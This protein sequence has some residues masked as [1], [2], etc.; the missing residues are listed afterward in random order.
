MNVEGRWE[1][2]VGVMDGAGVCVSHSI[3]YLGERRV[4]KKTQ[5]QE[6]DDSIE[7]QLQMPLSMNNSGVGLCVLVYGQLYDKHIQL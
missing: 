1:S 4:P 6:W 2:G 7:S 3:L 5:R